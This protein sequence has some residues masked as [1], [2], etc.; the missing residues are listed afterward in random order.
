MLCTWAK[1][2]TI[3][4]QIIVAGTR[5]SAAFTRVARLT[6]QFMVGQKISRTRIKSHEAII[7]NPLTGAIW[8]SLTPV[9][10]IGIH[11]T[12]PSW[13]QSFKIRIHVGKWTCSRLMATIA[14]FT[15]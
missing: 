14:H 13:S 9:G 3:D 5:S 10:L 4:S 12:F 15:S 7:V 1:P 8:P 2:S 11:V 6:E